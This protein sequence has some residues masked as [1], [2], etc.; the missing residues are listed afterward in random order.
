MK[1]I[2]RIQAG[3]GLWE[4]PNVAATNESGFSGLPAGYRSTNGSFNL[5]G[6]RGIWWSSS[7]SSTTGA[8]GRYLSFHSGSAT[9]YATNKVSGYSVRCL[10]D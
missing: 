10:R 9:S 4:D 5:F 6:N 3:T 2:G 7:E 8:W 1:S